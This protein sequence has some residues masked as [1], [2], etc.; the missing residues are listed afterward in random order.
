MSINYKQKEKEAAID[1]YSK[2]VLRSR[3]AFAV[4]QSEDKVLA[5]MLAGGDGDL[6]AIVDREG[7]IPHKFS[8]N[9][10]FLAYSAE[11]M[12]SDGL[13]NVDSDLYFFIQNKSGVIASIKIR[14]LGQF[15]ITLIPSKY[16]DNA[17]QIM[18]ELLIK[19]KE[20]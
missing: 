5:A 12:I 10:A 17:A 3:L 9:M 14:P 11:H 1:N 18:R 2:A 6:I 15:L 4:S 13:L 16:A 7:I 19:L 8:F 20:I